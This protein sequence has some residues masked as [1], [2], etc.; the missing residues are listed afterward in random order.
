M[1]ASFCATRSASRR[2]WTR[3]SAEFLRI[4]APVF[5]VYTTVEPFGCWEVNGL[6]AVLGLMAAVWSAFAN[7]HVE[8]AIKQAANRGNFIEYLVGGLA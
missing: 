5:E 3:G 8:P 1:A 2:A 6:A 7:D 4:G